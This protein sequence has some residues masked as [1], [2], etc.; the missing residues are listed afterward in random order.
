MILNVHNPHVN[1]SPPVMFTLMFAKVNLICVSV[2]AWTVT[3]RED[4][5]L[6]QVTATNSNRAQ[7]SKR[8][9]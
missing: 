8:I 3:Q 2:A 4:P 5:A 1:V 7:R 9:N 6:T